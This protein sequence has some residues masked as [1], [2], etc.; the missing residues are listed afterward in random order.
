[1]CPYVKEHVVSEKCVQP[2]SYQYWSQASLF[3][4][5][6]GKIKEKL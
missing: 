3:S 5:D 6:S 2:F 4:K 1:L